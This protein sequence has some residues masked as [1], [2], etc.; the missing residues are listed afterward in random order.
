MLISIS[1][2]EIMSITEKELLKQL[3]ALKKELFTIAYWVNGSVIETT[4]T[5]STNTKPFFYLSQSIKGKTK[6]TYISAAQ[7]ES[8]KQAVI[9]GEKAKEIL[10]KINNIHIQLI[11][12]RAQ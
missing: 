6:T 7:L 10:G 11:K 4:R 12:A 5:Q 1:N 3:E 9:D 8:F 2:E